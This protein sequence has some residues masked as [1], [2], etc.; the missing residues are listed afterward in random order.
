[1]L[2]LLSV[3]SWAA[4]DPATYVSG[5]VSAIPANMDG[6]LDL[7]EAGALHF[8]YGATSYDVPYKSITDF[9]LGR[10][11]QGVASQVGGG[12][13]KIGKT[14][15]PMFFSNKQYLT[16]DFR[17]ER[18]TN[19]QRL[20][21]QLRGNEAKAVLPVLEARVA[22]PETAPAAVQAAAAGQRTRGV[23]TVGEWWGDAIWRTNR[24]KDIWPDRPEER[25]ADTSKGS[26]VEVASKDK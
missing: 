24:N 22:K 19:T 26:S 3:S 16:I 6:M 2:F 4:G 13:A 14:V 11:N 23:G 8:R 21:L 15:L 12:A 5:T 10:D 25:T 20:V 17:T 9:H 7:T 1:M 18:S